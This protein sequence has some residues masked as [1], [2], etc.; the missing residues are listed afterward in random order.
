LSV[1][2]GRARRNTGVV[3]NETEVAGESAAGSGRGK[4]GK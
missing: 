3:L 2:D 1:V 4:E